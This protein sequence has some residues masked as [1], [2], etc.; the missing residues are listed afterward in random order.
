MKTR[1]KW[2]N[3]HHRT[4][5]LHSNQDSWSIGSDER[6]PEKGR[7]TEREDASGCRVIKWR[8]GGEKC[9]PSNRY[10]KCL[11]P[12]LLGRLDLRSRGDAITE[13]RGKEMQSKERERQVRK[14]RQ[15]KKEYKGQVSCCWQLL[16]LSSSSC[17]RT[18]LLQPAEPA[19]AVIVQESLWRLYLRT[20][21]HT[22][23]Y[24]LKLSSNSMN[25]TTLM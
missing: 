5:T 17:T 3:I 16:T 2:S 7:E 22:H 11:G 6:K 23:K 19:E 4:K 21:T 13:R 20:H 9:S 10:R 12:V 8:D 25:L 18:T 1:E 24:L 15:G 14:E